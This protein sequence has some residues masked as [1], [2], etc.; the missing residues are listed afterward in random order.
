MGD[1]ACCILAKT[2]S[3]SQ[4]RRMV[5]SAASPSVPHFVALNLEPS[6]A[7]ATRWRHLATRAL[8]LPVVDF[9]DFDS[10]HVD[11]IVGVSPYR[12]QARTGVAVLDSTM[13]R[14]LRPLWLR[15]ALLIPSGHA[16]KA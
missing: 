16:K 11:R 7:M 1:C 3:Q 8:G 4:G 15:G 13:R 9:A 5:C 2:Q 14:G 10:I 12:L 6:R